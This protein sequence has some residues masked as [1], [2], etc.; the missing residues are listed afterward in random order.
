MRSGGVDESGK[1]GATDPK[2]AQRA[3][4]LREAASNSL[5]SIVFMTSSSEFP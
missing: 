2:T 3:P 5:P 4:F 1:S